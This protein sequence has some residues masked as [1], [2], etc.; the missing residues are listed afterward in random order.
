MP[1]NPTDRRP[2][3]TRYL[4]WLQATRGLAFS[5]YD[6]LWRWSVCC[7]SSSMRRCTDC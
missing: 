4:D 7:R 5:D 3:I 6:A 1:P 2:H